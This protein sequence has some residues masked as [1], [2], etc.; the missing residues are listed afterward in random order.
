MFEKLNGMNIKKKLDTGYNIVIA[1]MA[2][3]G[4]VSMLALGILNYNVNDF[5]ERVNAA[6]TAVKICRIDINI[7]ARTVREMAL[8]SDRTAYPEY[9]A[10]IE[11]KLA[12]VDEQLAILG[13]T[14]V[15]DEAD[16]NDYKNDIAS[17]RSDAEKIIEE[18]Q[19]GNQQKAAEMILNQCAPAL[20]EVVQ[21]SARLDSETDIAMTRKVQQ[22]K[23]VFTLGTAIV[24]IFVVIATILAKKIGA[25]IVGSIIKP[26]EQ[27][28]SAAGSLRVGDLSVANQITYE[29]EDE[30]GHLAITMRESIE[31]LDSYV[32]N[33]VENF[34]KVASGDLTK[35]FNEIPDYLGDFGSIKKSFVIILKEFNETLS[36]I[37]E[38]AVQVDRGSDEIA[39]A[40]NELANGTSEQVSAV[41]ELTATIENVSQMAENA[42]IQA[43]NTYNSMME[44]VDKAMVERRQMQELQVEMQHI[45]EISNEIETI[46]TAIE[47]IASQTSLLA[48][49][50]SIE[51]A[52]AGDAGRGFAVVADQ[53]GKLATD[54]AKA[55]VSTKELI[56][57]TIEEIDNGNKITE[58]TAA[59]FERIIKDM[60]IFAESAKATKEVSMSQ[61]QALSEVGEGINQISTVTQQ[62]AAASEECS[63][64]SEELAARA[65]ELENMVGNFKLYS[66]M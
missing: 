64:I 17:W 21:I 34:E 9:I 19:K 37:R 54:S 40:S 18:L 51:A 61:S 32:A 3:S 7:A 52:R 44:S 10:T 2:I 33:I 14:G 8:N 59:G 58:T 57:K 53:I 23:M 15:V 65:A 26:I 45:K 60:E 22:S 27:I 11:E 55:V 38:S 28:E 56:G 36:G 5:V 39:G 16:Y 50:A 20:S 42:A 13:A 6:D 24:V 35:D 29:S 4:L 48:L 63:A 41:E 12:E 46:V 49:N 1:F 66:T 30:L 31:I 62:N 43:E 25:A 47:E